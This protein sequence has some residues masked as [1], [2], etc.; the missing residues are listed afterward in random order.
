MASLKLATVLLSVNA[1]NYQVISKV[2]DDDAGP[3]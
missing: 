2:I 1:R 3:G